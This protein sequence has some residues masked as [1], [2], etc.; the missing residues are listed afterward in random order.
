MD[1]EFTDYKDSTFE[2]VYSQGGISTSR[3]NNIIKE[4]KRILKPYGL[5]CVG[6]MVKLKREVPKVIENIFDSSDIVPYD[7]DSLIEYY[8]DKK[9]EVL[10]SKDL[11]YTLKSYYSGLLS[12]LNEKIREMEDREKSYYKKLLNRISHEANV[13]LSQGG[14]RYIGF[15]TLLLKKS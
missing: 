5:L 8:N 6:E 13:Y 9:F 4:I 7:N 15:V 10:K 1:F 14:N 12:K 3:R 2:L 11:S